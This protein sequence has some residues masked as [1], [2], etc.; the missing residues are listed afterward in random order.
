[1]SSSTQSEPTRNSKYAKIRAA[2][3]VSH[4]DHCGVAMRQDAHTALAELEAEDA[5]LR[6]QEPAGVA[7]DSTQTIGAVLH[8]EII[9]GTEIA[10]GTKLYANPA[11]SRGMFTADEMKSAYMNGRSDRAYPDP[12]SYTWAASETFELINER[13][14]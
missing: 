7:T 6:A 5:L 4:D 3:D 8:Q 9:V 2:L 11:P 1:M 12:V 13:M 14:K 10:H